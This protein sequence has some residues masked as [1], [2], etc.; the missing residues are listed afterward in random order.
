MIDLREGQSSIQALVDQ[1]REEGFWCKVRLDSDHRLTAIFFAHPDSVAYLQYNPD[2]LL[3]DCTYKTNKHAMPLLDMVGVDSCQRSFCIAFAFLSGESEVDYLWTLHHLK[4]LYQHELPTVVLT[5]RCLAAINATA[6]LFPASKALLCLWHVNKAV[7]QYCQPDFVQK[8]S[9]PSGGAEDAWNEFY[10]FWHSI[11]DSPTEAVYEERLAKFELK[12]AK[13]QPRAVGAEGI[14]SLI[15]SYIKTSTFDLFDSW[16]AMRHAITNQLKELN[17]MRASQQIRTPLDVSGEMFEAVH[18]WVSHQALRKV[19]E[20]RQLLSAPLKSPCSQ[21]FTSS[22]GLP[23]SHTLK[24]L[25]DAKQ[26]LLLEHF[27]PHWN[28]R[29]GVDR[30]QPILEPRR[31]PKQ[32]PQTTGQPRTSTRREPCGFEIVQ[33]GKK[34][35][36]TC[37]RC[38]EVGHMRS[39]RA[40]PLRFQE[41]L[42]K[43]APA[44]PVPQPDAASVAVPA[45][46]DPPPSVPVTR[47]ASLLGATLDIA[48]RWASHSDVQALYRLNRIKRMDE[49][50]DDGVFGLEQGGG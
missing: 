22:Y 17:H 15:K 4:S 31:V 35:P 18:G 41:L 50:G 38:H 43:A 20:Q 25:E 39:S 21:S 33:S 19:Q 13:S 27:N 47:G 3:L 44:K 9:Q 29:R 2:V 40:C 23:C 26:C 8:S 36:S 14:H 37:S 11:V 12:Y 16:Q 34:A 49:R 45:F 6:T 46:T 5:D 1:L 30:P 10:R 32:G 42:T 7:L 28:L 48:G 24:K